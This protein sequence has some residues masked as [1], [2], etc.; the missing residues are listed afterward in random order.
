VYLGGASGGA[1]SAAGCELAE[2]SAAIDQ[3]RQTFLLNL[4]KYELARVLAARA[5]DLQLA[6]TTAYRVNAHATD[7][8]VDVAERE[9]WAG[10]LGDYQL[11]RKH[12]NGHAK[13]I[14]LK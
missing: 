10:Q 1:V 14:F 6:A 13:S 11:V 3:E 7:S 2:P 9:L 4:S 12:A 5:Q 8:L